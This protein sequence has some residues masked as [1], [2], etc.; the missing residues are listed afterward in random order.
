MNRPRNL[1]SLDMNLTS[2]LQHTA[3]ISMKDAASGP[4]ISETA[5][6]GFVIILAASVTEYK[7]NVHSSIINILE[8]FPSSSYRHRPC[9]IVAYSTGGIYYYNQLINV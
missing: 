8:Q 6:D 7:Q 3:L 5:A 1:D 9:S 4:W 2:T